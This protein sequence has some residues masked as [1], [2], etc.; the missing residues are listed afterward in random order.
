[1]LGIVLRPKAY[2]TDQFNFGFHVNSNKIIFLTISLLVSISAC[3]KKPEGSVC[4][5]ENDLYQIETQGFSLSIPVK[6]DLNGGHHYFLTSSGSKIS[7]DLDRIMYFEE[8]KQVF[9][10]VPGIPKRFILVET[11]CKVGLRLMLK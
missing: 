4:L 3:S 11:E 10:S 7:S 6:P 2:G 5:F 1:M 8:K 9:L